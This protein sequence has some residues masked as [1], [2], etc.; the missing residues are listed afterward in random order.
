MYNVLKFKQKNLF[1]KII[2]T[3]VSYVKLFFD[4]NVFDRYYNDETFR[5]KVDAIYNKIFQFH[6]DDYLLKAEE[7]AEKMTN[8]DIKKAICENRINK[9]YRKLYRYEKMNAG[10]LNNG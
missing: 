6:Y 5:L 4:E 10:S 8:K 1:K 2:L 3:I 7:Y 9:L